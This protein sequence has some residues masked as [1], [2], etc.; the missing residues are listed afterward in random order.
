LAALLHGIP[1]LGVS[2]TLR[3]WTE[4]ATYIRQGGHHVGHWPTFL[5]VFGF[6]RAV[7]AALCAFLSCSLPLLLFFSHLFISTNK[8]R[9]WWRRCQLSSIIA[10][11][12]RSLPTYVYNTLTVT[13][14][15]ARFAY[16]S[17]DTAT[18]V[19]AYI[20]A[21][22]SLVRLRKCAGALGVL[23]SE[24]RPAT[25]RLSSARALSKKP[26]PSPAP[27]HGQ[28]IVNKAAR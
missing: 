11:F 9:W 24:I 8:W 21:G 1:V 6:S 16:E 10:S 25:H 5:V 27:C 12:S 14:G 13:S 7:V 22:Y 4:G 23:S 19:P 2:Q 17:W 28:R 15:V 3:R 26:L 18:Q 20:P